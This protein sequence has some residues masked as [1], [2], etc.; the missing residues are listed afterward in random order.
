MTISIELLLDAQSEALVR[1]DWERLER[2]GHSSLAAHRAP[3]NRPHITLLVRPEL[4]DVAFEDAVAALPLALRL[5]DPLI[6]DHGERVVVARSV[7]LDEPL[8]DVHR[9]VHDAVPPGED[10]PHTRPGDWTPHVTL[11]RRLR[12][13]S[14]DDALRLLAPGQAA[15][16]V[17]LRR[18]D[19]EARTI[20]DL[21]PA[22]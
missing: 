17:S 10:A 11:A 22:S 18:W 20:T 14:L 16:A 13:E 1:A 2:A 9:A 4:G 6:F 7:R 15:Q 3:S 5:G 21:G 19:S 8:A 12:R